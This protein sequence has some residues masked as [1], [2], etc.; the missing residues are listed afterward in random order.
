M[1]Y[2]QAISP[3]GRVL[4]L[5]PADR[6]AFYRDELGAMLIP[7]PGVN[8]ANLIEWA[9]K[10]RL[11]NGGREKPEEHADRHP[12]DQAAQQR[13]AFGDLLDAARQAGAD[14]V[15][16]HDALEDEADRRRVLQ[17]ASRCGWGEWGLRADREQVGRSVCWRVWAKGERESAE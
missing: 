17:R 15:L 10:L 1:L 14:G 12:R 3:D 11:A 7:A 4:G 8:S 13:L 5:V 2:Y 9:R 16:L 6:A